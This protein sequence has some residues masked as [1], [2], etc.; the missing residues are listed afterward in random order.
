M[1][2]WII[3]LLLFCVNFINAQNET[4]IKG[5]LVGY[6]GK[7]MIKAH[8]HPDF[9]GVHLTRP[10]TMPDTKSIK[11][12]HVEKD[13]T[14]ELRT[15]ETGIFILQFTGVHH[16][17]HDVALYLDQP[18]SLELKIRLRTYNYVDNFNNV[19]I[20]GDFN[21]FSFET[22][23]KLEKQSDETYIAKFKTTPRF[24]RGT[25]DKFAYQLL[26][27]AK[28]MRSIN[29]TQS[30]D[31]EY[32]GAGDYK[33]IIFPKDTVVKIIFDPAKLIRSDAKAEIKF[34]NTDST[35]MKFSQIYDEQK[36]RL[37]DYQKALA[38]HMLSGKPRFYRG[39]PFEELVYDWSIELEIIKNRLEQE[40][41]PL[42]RQTLLLNYIE[43]TGFQKNPDTSYAKKCLEEIQPT[44]P[45]WSL[46]PALLPGIVFL[47][48]EIEKHID[49]IQQVLDKHSD[50]NVKATLLFN[51]IGLATNE[52]KN[53]EAKKYYDRLINEYSDNFYANYAKER[54]NPDR[55]ILPGNFI[56][57]FTLT[58]LDDSTIIYNNEYFK[59]KILLI[60][61]WA[62]WCKPCVGEM[63]H[64]HNAYE[65]YKDKNFDI[66]SISFDAKLEDV[67]KFRNGKWKMPWHN[68]FVSGSF[69]SEIAKKFEVIGIPKPVLID[70]SGKIIAVEIKL[71]G[72]S[73]E[74]TLSETFKPRKFIRSD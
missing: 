22:A 50:K 34:L 54:F 25:S 26:G 53:E 40:T 66:L 49:Y 19:K 38:D 52:G 18:K 16:H 8:V 3:V 62:V 69:K 12:I 41:N 7:P 15:E 63:E 72:K 57:E 43:I 33:S 64:L 71:R 35:T 23:Q 21:D 5:T 10:S 32:D 73:L 46:N 42:L 27:A 74:K 9:I 47:T 24:Y 1:K 39:K 11:S 51:L 59:G 70:E 56:P 65:K 29:G 68:S 28:D 17:I 36:K 14:F 37:D 67:I 45:L 31:Y 44:S 55:K 60:D 2:Y 13:G 4:I 61:F 6:D 30:D 48:G 58:S 20:I